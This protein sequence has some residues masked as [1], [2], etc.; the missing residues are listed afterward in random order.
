MIRVKTAGNVSN[1]Q[2]EQNPVCVL[3]ELE[4]QYNPVGLCVQW[5][6]Y[7]ARIKR[8]SVNHSKLKV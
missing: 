2:L 5:K 8:P 3:V 1:V 6:I 7:S 4:R